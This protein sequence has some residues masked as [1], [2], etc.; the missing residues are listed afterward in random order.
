MI[1]V[2]YIHTTSD[3]RLDT[4]LTQFCL[5]QFMKSL[6]LHSG[7]CNA[8][9]WFMWSLCALHGTI[10]SNS[11]IACPISGTSSFR[12]RYS[13]GLKHNPLLV[14]TTFSFG[15]QYCLMSTHW[16]P[17]DTLQYT[18]PPRWVSY[19][20]LSAKA[21][22]RHSTE[23]TQFFQRIRVKRMPFFIGFPSCHSRKSTLISPFHSHT[24]ATRPFP[25]SYL[26]LE[27]GM[28]LDRCRNGQAEKDCVL[29]L[30]GSSSM[31]GRYFWK[32]HH[33]RCEH[34]VNS[35]LRTVMSF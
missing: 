29:L 2:L 15:F 21:P 14:G 11:G 22:S 28:F 5:Y 34:S 10:P 19:S 30:A 3:K 6:G 31:I 20:R 7:H 13:E 32:C 25:M 33:T 12:R 16:L 26:H 8:P 35:K 1:I 4:L 18:L 17:S 24:S 9:I 23:S 27:N